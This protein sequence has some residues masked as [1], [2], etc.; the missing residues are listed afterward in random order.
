MARSIWRRPRFVR[1]LVPSFAATA[2]MMLRR[3]ARSLEVAGLHPPQGLL[4]KSIGGAIFTMSS[5]AL[6]AAS[7]MFGTK[8]LPALPTA[9]DMFGTT[10]SLALPPASDPE[11]A[12]MDGSHPVPRLTSP[13]APY[14]S[15]SNVS[16]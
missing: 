5:P 4:M 16:V 7:D 12:A 13:C 11:T 14:A 8:M 9:C 10:M 3:R 2:S 1:G 15:A 6:P